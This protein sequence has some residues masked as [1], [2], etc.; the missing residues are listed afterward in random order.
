MPK[1]KVSVWYFT[2]LKQKLTVPHC[3]MP[4]VSY[5]QEAPFFWFWIYRSVPEISAIDVWSCPNWRQVLHVFGPHFWG[6]GPKFQ[7]L[8]Y[9]T[10][11]TSNHMARFRGD[12]PTELK[13]HAKKKTSAEKHKNAG[14]DCSEQ[15]KSCRKTKIG[16]NIPQAGVTAKPIFSSKS[17]RPHNVGTSPTYSSGY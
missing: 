5:A 6:E 11:L 16:V 4:I 9:K 14:N 15:T 13:D 3:A 7:N 1:P 17:G 12:R 8:N 2:Y 10:E